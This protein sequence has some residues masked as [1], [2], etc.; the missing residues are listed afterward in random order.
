MNN[1][2]IH[3]PILFL[4]LALRFLFIAAV[5]QQ[6]MSGFLRRKIVYLQQYITP[7]TKFQKQKKASRK[8]NV[9]LFSQSLICKEINVVMLPSL[10]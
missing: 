4:L 2:S 7:M 5:R 6:Q 10:P 9:Q 8:Q 1:L 3:R